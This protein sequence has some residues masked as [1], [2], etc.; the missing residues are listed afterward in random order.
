M[1][2]VKTPTDMANFMGLTHTL[3]PNN[4]LSSKN[5]IISMMKNARKLKAPNHPNLG[6]LLN[7]SSNNFKGEMDFD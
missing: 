5:E 3:I 7:I 1:V 2:Q 6:L 4:I